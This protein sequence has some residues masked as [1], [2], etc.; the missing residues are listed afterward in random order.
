MLRN[1]DF[2]QKPTAEIVQKI[3]TMLSFVSNRSFKC[4]LMFIKGFFLWSNDLEATLR[5]WLTAMEEAADLKVN[6]SIF[7]NF[8]LNKAT[9]S[10]DR[11]FYLSLSPWLRTIIVT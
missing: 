2:R 8:L 9:G 1:S 4:Q 5:L 10:I 3:D 7:S 11:I 6:V